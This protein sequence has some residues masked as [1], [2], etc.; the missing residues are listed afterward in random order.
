M[1]IGYYRCDLVSAT[2]VLRNYLRTD[3]FSNASIREEDDE[4]VIN[5]KIKV[6]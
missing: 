5:L 3:I 1:Q 2:I 6:I 4:I